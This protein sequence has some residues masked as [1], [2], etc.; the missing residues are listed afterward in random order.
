MEDHLNFSGFFNSSG[1]KA[2]ISLRSLNGKDD[3]VRV[4]L[5]ERLSL[6]E[7]EL[8]KLV[9]IHS[10][11]IEFLN[12]VSIS[13]EA[14]GFITRN[15][16]LVLSIKIADC[17]HL[18]LFESK[19]GLTGLIHSGWR[20]TVGEIVVNGIELMIENGGEQSHIQAL[21][22]PSIC[23]DHFEIKNDIVSQFPSK[24]V[25]P[26]NRGS[27]GVDLKGMVFDQLISM[28][29]KSETIYNCNLCTFCREDMFFSYRRDKGIEGQ[30]IAMMG[31]SD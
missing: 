19:T 29:V 2:G 9:Q 16:N 15:K 1:L 27:F 21:I 11:N 30:M 5:V 7:N 3:Q 25:E 14:D 18:F 4:K 28:G 31:W 23:R 13:Q 8:C 22:G 10:N 17:I 20:G 24:Y 6:K 26:N 12:E